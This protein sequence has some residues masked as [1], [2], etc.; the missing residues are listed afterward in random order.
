MRIEFEQFEQVVS[1]AQKYYE[2]QEAALEQQ[3]LR[4][5]ARA[6]DLVRDRALTR[7]LTLGCAQ[8][9]RTALDLLKEALPTSNR[10][11]DIRQW[12]QAHGN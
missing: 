3:K 9:L 10:E 5:L 1:L 11:I 2:Q 6:L 12:W 4:N 8:A 7:T